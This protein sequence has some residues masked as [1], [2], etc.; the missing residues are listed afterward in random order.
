MDGKP[1]PHTHTPN[2][3]T[4]TQHIMQSENFVNEALA[5]M[6]ENLQAAQGAKQFGIVPNGLSCCLAASTSSPCRPIEGSLPHPF[7]GF[8]FSFLFSAK[9]LLIQ[10]SHLVYSWRMDQCQSLVQL[11]KD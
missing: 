2:P 10:T 8:V 9:H 6:W 3:K 4:R 5:K 1:N 7:C 11:N